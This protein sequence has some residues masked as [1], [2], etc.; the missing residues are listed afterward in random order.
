MDVSGGVDSA[1]FADIL[2]LMC[3]TQHVRSPT[4][5]QGHILDL[6]ITRNFD[7][8]IQGRLSLIG[9]FPIIALCCAVSMLPNHHLL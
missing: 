2:E 4:H 6:V 1:K 9:I 5:I 3:L 8:I 7:D